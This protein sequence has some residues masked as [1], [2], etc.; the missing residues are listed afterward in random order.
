MTRTLAGMGDPASILGLIERIAYRR[1]I[2]D[3][4]A[5]GVMR[6]AQ[7]I[8]GGAEYYALHV[9]GVELPRQEPRIAKGFGLG[10]AVGN[11]G[12][13]HL[14][15]LPTIDLAGKWEVAEQLFPADIVEELMDTANEKY[16]A[17]VVLY[18]EHFSA[19]ADSLGL[20]KFSTPRPMW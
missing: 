20:C 4:L 10:H 6:A 5:E 14:Y 2:G 8:G 18:G 17:D 7:G 13:D 16:K 11:R 19:V 15:A 3:L 9:K 1:G 12:A